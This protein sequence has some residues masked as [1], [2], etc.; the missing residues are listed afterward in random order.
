LLRCARLQ[1]FLFAGT[2]ARGEPSAAIYSQLGF[3]MLN[4][5]DPEIYLYH[6]IEQ[7]FTD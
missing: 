5:L 2:D 3:A 4:D 7:N 6:V 1:K